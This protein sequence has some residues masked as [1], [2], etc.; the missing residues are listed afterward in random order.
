MHKLVIIS[1]D[2]TQLEE[3]NFM[4]DT[5]VTIGKSVIQHG[6]E[7][8]R[9]YLMKLKTQDVL[10]IIQRLDKMA[11]QNDYSKVFA[12]IP[13]E[14]KANFIQSDYTQEAT[15]P[16]FFEGREDAF[17]MGKYF[18]PERSKQKQ[19][20]I[21]EDVL[22]VTQ[23]KENIQKIAPLEKP[24]VCS[25]AREQ[26]AQQMADVYKKVFASYP[27]PIDDPAYIRKTMNE[28]IIY[29]VIWDKDKIAGIASS[30]MDIEGENVEMTDFAV[31]PE[32]RG[33]HF[34][35]YL[36]DQMETEMKKQGIKTTY[37]IARAL[38]YGM[39]STFSKM[40]YAF[41]G[42]LVNN[43]NISGGLESMNVWYKALI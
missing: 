16:C 18:S 11:K 5:I 17:F 28:N 4:S 21:I 43:T 35:I 24:F 36:L 42:T 27:F 33:N 32:Y 6:K 14:A 15:I 20:D 22:K 10:G 37:T 30:E 40:G 12:K 13:A 41:G 19:A 34:S 2:V 31:L 29:Y 7:N 23:Q 3:Y 8:D 26:D 39:N 25:K 1:K 9:I 38:S